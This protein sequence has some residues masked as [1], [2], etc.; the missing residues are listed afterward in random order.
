ML[1]I[2]PLVAHLLLPQSCTCVKLALSWHDRMSKVV[3]CLRR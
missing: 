2:I 3:R 1:G